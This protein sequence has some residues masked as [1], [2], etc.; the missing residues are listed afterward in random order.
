LGSSEKLRS[1]TGFTPKYTFEE[2]I[3]ETISWFKQNA[4]AYKTGIYNI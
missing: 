3:A 4:A 1:L 2:G